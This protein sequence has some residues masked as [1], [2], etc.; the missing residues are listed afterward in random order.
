MFLY[1]AKTYKKNKLMYLYLDLKLYLMIKCNHA[2]LYMYNHV[3]I[4]VYGKEGI[5]Y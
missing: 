2:C 3:F 4:N 5:R 1:V